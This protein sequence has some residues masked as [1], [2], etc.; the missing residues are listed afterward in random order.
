MTAFIVSIQ[1]TFIISQFSYVF[2]NV[3]YLFVHFIDLLGLVYEI[4]PEI[5]VKSERRSLKREIKL[6]N[7]ADKM[8]R[9]YTSNF[10]LHSASYSAFI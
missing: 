6:P 4:G 9:L 2:L 8:V 3:V 1:H 5:I 7:S 10:L